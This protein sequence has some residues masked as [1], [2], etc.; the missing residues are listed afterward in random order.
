[1]VSLPPALPVGDAD[2]LGGGACAEGARRR[3]RGGVSPVLRDEGDT[4][5]D[6]VELVGRPEPFRAV[7]YPWRL[8]CGTGALD[9]L[10]AEVARHGARH[11]FVICGQTVAQRTNLLARIRDRLGD[12]Y[13]GVFD[14]MDKDSS[15]PAVRAA[16]DAA[17]AAEADLLIAVGG[18]SVIVGA[19]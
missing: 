10:P 2:L 3:R 4:M 19:R 14:R 11:A 16:T 1:R 12:V 15:Y 18:G 8:Y 13:G 7:S 9:S 17:R 6:A 5:S